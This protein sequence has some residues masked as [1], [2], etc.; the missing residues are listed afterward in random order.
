MGRVLALKE[1]LKACRQAQ[2]KRASSGPPATA[3][4]M[5]Q[6]DC[7][8]CPQAAGGRL[9][10][11]GAERSGPLRRAGDCGAQVH[12]I[13]L[14]AG[15]SQPACRSNRRAVSAPAVG[16][17]EPRRGTQRHSLGRQE[18]AP[19]AATFNIDCE[20]KGMSGIPNRIIC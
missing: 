13:C 5:Q 16:Q 20:N 3:P 1:N 2:P 9:A 7:G 4:R 10:C 18:A 17:P 15:Q 6:G 14:A 12:T 8:N 11:A 19:A